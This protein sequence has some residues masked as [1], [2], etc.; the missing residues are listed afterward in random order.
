[1]LASASRIEM[2][3]VAPPEDFGIAAIDPPI[4]PGPKRTF[5]A[6]LSQC[7]ATS[8]LAPLALPIAQT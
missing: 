7:C 2:F 4:S 5:L 3:R 1:M 6:C 8:K